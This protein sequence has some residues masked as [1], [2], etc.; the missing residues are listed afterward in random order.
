MQT[1]FRYIL[2]FGKIYGTRTTYPFQSRREKI[3][4]D[5]L[6][7]F[8]AIQL[9]W[10]DQQLFPFMVFVQ[11]IYI[12]CSFRLLPWFVRLFGWSI[13]NSIFL[14]WHIDSRFHLCIVYLIGHAWQKIVRHWKLPQ[15]TIK[16]IEINKRCTKEIF[17][18]GK[19]SKAKTDPGNCWRIRKNY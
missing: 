9:Y 10:Y 7:M 8:F 14:C 19:Q 13:R 3:K 2:R 11:K 17:H 18:T 6:L 16:K 4:V 1:L 12:N 15:A 5:L